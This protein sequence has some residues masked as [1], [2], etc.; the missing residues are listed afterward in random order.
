MAPD[1][2]PIPS[3]FARVTS[4]THAAATH[5]RFPAGCLHG[6]SAGT[7]VAPHRSPFRDRDAVGRGI[8][9]VGCCCCEPLQRFLEDGRLRLDNNRFE[10]T[11]PSISVARKSW[12]FF[13]SD[14]HANAAAYLFSLVASC[15]RHSI[16]PDQY[17]AEVPARHGLLAA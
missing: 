16:Y 13:G 9:S 8:N 11:L 5:A 14:D 10:S 3:L 7:R 1:P 2:P 17:V 12:L 15:K 4:G 6:G